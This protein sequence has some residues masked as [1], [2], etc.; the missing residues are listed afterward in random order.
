LIC[1]T[2]WD[3]TS[4]KKCVTKSWEPTNTP[5]MRRPPMTKVQP[6]GI[7]VPGEILDGLQSFH[8]DILTLSPTRA[9]WVERWSKA[10]AII[11]NINVLL[12]FPLLFCNIYTLN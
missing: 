5:K 2:S 11:F 4:S 6:W 7:Y 1:T 10:H 8:F 12:I 3:K 9:N